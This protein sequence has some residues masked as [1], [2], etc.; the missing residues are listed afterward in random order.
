MSEAVST[1]EW[2]GTPLRHVL[3]RAGLKPDCVE[4][5]FHGI[6]SGFDAGNEHEYGR[7][8]KP[9]HAMH[10]DVM[11]VWAMNGQP[12]LPQHGFPLRMIV[13]GWYGMASV[14]WLD[15]IVALGEA[16]QGHQQVGTYHYRETPDGPRVPVTTMKV[17]SLMVPPG[18]PDWYSRKRLVKAGATTIFGRA[19]SG[20][21][22]PI[23]KVEIAFNGVWHEAAL[24]KPAAS[25][26]SWRGWRY[27]WDAKPGA[28]DIMC[29]A[30]DAAGNVQPIE[31]VP[32]VGGFGNNSVQRIEVFV[33]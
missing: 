12:L 25:R 28:Y 31:A 22:T 2:T 21:A 7:S 19:W 5:S 15:R 27:A 3:E 16:Y 1:A 4:I 29:R 24:D 17:K 9:A 14:K 18:L 23:A 13:P 33:Q 32:D 20:A 8:M 10:E 6:D 11:L 30:T 26:Y